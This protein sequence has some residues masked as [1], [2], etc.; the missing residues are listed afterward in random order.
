MRA[1]FTIL[2]AGL[3]L[4]ALFPLHTARAA[5]LD[6]DLSTAQG[7]P[8]PSQVTIGGVTANG[9]VVNNGQ[10]QNADLWSNNAGDEHGV[11]VCSEGSAACLGAG[12]VNEI[13]NQLNSE[14]LRLTRPNGRT[15]T[16]LW[17]SSLD[18]GGSGNNETGTLYW[19]NLAQPD[20][21]TLSTKRVFSH[22]DLGGATEGDL[23]TLPGFAGSFDAGAKYVFFSAGPNAAGT[24]NDYL[25]WGGNLSPVPEPSA[26]LAMLAGLGALVTSTGRRRRNS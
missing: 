20:L 7:N 24:D 10:Y 23:F 12:D 13:S 3:L 1:S 22:S 17:V 25:V 5:I 19:S 14:V 16:S 11:G 26:V 9:F 21:S 15:W 8:V 18:S 6:F 2:S 4:G